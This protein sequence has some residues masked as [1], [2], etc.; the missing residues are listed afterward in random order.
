MTLRSNRRAPLI[1]ISITCI[2]LALIGAACDPKRGG[3]SPGGDA[4]RTPV[5]RPAPCRR[6]VDLDRGMFA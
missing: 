3:R 1:L 6:V 4:K 2:V 5:T